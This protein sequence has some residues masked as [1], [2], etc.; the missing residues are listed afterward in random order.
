M[1][2]LADDVAGGLAWRGVPQVLPDGIHVH[3]AI[4]IR[5]RYF[6]LRRDFEAALQ[7]RRRQIFV[8]WHDARGLAFQIAQLRAIFWSPRW[9]FLP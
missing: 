4:E 7:I 6:L 3:V 9:L 2:E 5:Q 1:L 8:R